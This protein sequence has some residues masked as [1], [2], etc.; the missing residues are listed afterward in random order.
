M[1]VTDIDPNRPG[2]EIYMA[3]E[4][5]TGATY[6]YSLRVA[7]TGKVIYGAYTGLKVM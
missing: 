7:K 5:A 3:H 2:L 6:G 4:G 1:H